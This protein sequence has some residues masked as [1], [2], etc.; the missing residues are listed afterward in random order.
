MIIPR[1]F[2]VYQVANFALPIA[3]SRQV[4][5]PSAIVNKKSISN[6]KFQIQNLKL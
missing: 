4:V 5:F 2:L 6:L 1:A 3:D